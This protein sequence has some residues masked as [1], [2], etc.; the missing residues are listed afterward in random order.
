MP[1]VVG[2][3][4]RLFGRAEEKKLRTL[5]GSMVLALGLSSGHAGELVVAH[6]G[7]FSGPLS[8]N[9]LANY[10]GAKA[11]VDEV[12][13]GGGV[14]GSSLKLVREDDQYKPEETV[15]LLREVAQRERPVAFLNLLGSANVGAV[16]KDKT[17]EDLKV[18]V[19]GIT[20]GADVLRAA[21]N[22]WLFHVH[23]SDTAQLRRILNHLAT[24]GTKEIA[25]VYQDI[26]FGQGGL[27]FVEEAA[28]SLKLAITGRIPVPSAADDLR[29]QAAS[30]RAAKAQA[31]IMILAPNSGIAL[32][33]DVRKGGD[34]TPIYG[35]SYVPVKGIL[36]KA[37][38]DNAVGIGLAQVTPNTFSSSSGLVRQ[39]QAAME[40]HAGAGTG[41]SQLHLIGYLSCRVLVEGLRQA[42][43]APTPQK[44]QVALRKVRA[45]LG[46][47]V[48]DFSGGNEGAKYV[49]IGVVT[50]DGRL[51][52]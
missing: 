26:P 27:K 12:N 3:L 52:Y 47:Y 49:D 43:P 18:P 19:V 45:D 35:M 14:L 22:P 17:L 33:R 7:P 32:V 21:G 41:R 8:V 42:G 34:P 15:R 46:G 44:L 13:A 38:S 5:L 9:G 25:V 31:Y 50:R 36:D 40:K 23:A 48:V 4:D 24:L 16:L 39:F 11:C 28:P 10:E 30:L 6:V 37:G 2:T 51:M 29:S 1:H 20:P